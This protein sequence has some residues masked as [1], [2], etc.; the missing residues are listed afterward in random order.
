MLREEKVSLRKL[1]PHST[2]QCNSNTP[3]SVM[4]K[5]ISA[6]RGYLTLL[7]SHSPICFYFPLKK[8]PMSLIPHLHP[9][10][11]LSFCYTSRQSTCVTNA[12]TIFRHCLVFS[13]TEPATTLPFTWQLLMKSERSCKLV[14]GCFHFPINCPPAIIRFKLVIVSF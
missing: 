11:T 5:V 14:L 1:Y 4:R 12:T 6:R 8:C 10:T 2:K 9:E 3:A 13:F 7:K